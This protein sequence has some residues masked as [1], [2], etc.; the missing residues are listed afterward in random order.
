LP[1]TVWVEKVGKL[2]CR[3]SYNHVVDTRFA[4]RVKCAPTD[5]VGDLKK[6]IAAQTGTSA[7]KIQLKKWF[8]LCNV[9]YMLLTISRY[10]TYKDHVT[11]ADYEIHDGMVRV[12]HA[13]VL[14]LIL[15]IYTVLGDVLGERER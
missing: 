2:A 3:S 10:T 14:V 6:L 9:A 5:T 1:T 15:T 11:L 13:V 8:V 7:G 4:V 12:L